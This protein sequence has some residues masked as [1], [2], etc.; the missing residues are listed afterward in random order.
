AYFRR[1]P[2]QRKF[3]TVQF[4][5]MV[6]KVMHQVPL[7]RFFSSDFIN[8]L[9]ILSTSADIPLVASQPGRITSGPPDFHLVT[10]L[11]PVTLEL[12]RGSASTPN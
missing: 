6:I 4:I 5:I 12:I 11:C 9:S 3:L 8:A 10:G 7:L 1:Y 2:G